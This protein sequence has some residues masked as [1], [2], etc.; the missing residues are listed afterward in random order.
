MTPP[1]TFAELV[2]FLLD[3][4]NSIIP[5]LVL[6]TFLAIVWKVVDAWVINAADESK[7]ADGK[8]VVLTG[9]I[10]MVILVSIWG[11]MAL[12]SSSVFGR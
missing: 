1:S 7:R 5:L 10:V 8:V 9:I 3:L 6:L 4:I 2:A 12:L 11:I